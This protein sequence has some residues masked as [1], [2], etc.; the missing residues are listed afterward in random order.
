MDFDFHKKRTNMII[1]NIDSVVNKAFQKKNVVIEPFRKDTLVAMKIV[2]DFIIEKGRIIYGGIAQNEFIKLKNKDDAFYKE[3]SQEIPD[4]DI[5]SPEPI[6]DLVF[7]VNKLY[8][9]GFTQVHGREAVHEGTY[10]IILDR[11]TGPILDIH[12]VWNP[13]YNNIPKKK[14]GNFYYADPEFMMIDMYKICTDPLL[15]FD[16]RIEKV[17]KRTSLL[18]Q[19]YPIKADRNN[20]NK[21][22]FNNMNDKIKNIINKIV[23]EYVSNNTTVIISGIYCYNFYAQQVNKNNMVNLDHLTLVTDN[24]YR[25]CDQILNILIKLNLKDD[26]STVIY[27][28]FFETFDKKIQIKYKDTVI[29]E[30]FGNM[31][32]CIPYITHKDKS[33]LNINFISFH[34]LLLHFYGCLF[35]YKYNKKYNKLDFFKN[36]IYNLYETRNNYLKSKKLTGL[37]EG[38]FAELIVDCR[39]KT[40]DAR[41]KQDKKIKQN[42]KKGKAAMFTY[43]PSQKKMNESNLPQ[44]IFNNTSGNIINSA[45]SKN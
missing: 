43:R 44:F 4:Y 13:H 30:I 35:M 3:D 34:G 25:V 31:G 26:I 33:N 8:D 27:H 21:K 45:N 40:E 42:I 28:P 22:I 36:I 19:L 15:S 11:I 41:L 39:F 5:Y 10:T 38:I 18:E 7:L 9:N 1:D 37:E 32:R 14:I 17:F 24:I 29:V 16:F 12:Y 23:T 20:F 2:T 6:K